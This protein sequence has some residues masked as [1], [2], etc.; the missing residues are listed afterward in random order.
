MN[1]TK[2]Q[3]AKNALNIRCSTDAG[4]MLEQLLGQPTA[5][6]DIGGAELCLHYCLT[7]PVEDEAALK[8]YKQ[9]REFAAK[10]TGGPSNGRFDPKRWQIIGHSPNIK[11]ALDTAWQV[12]WK[13]T[14]NGGEMLTQAQKDALRA[15]GLSDEDISI[16]TPEEAEKVIRNIS[17][18]QAQKLLNGGRPDRT[19]ALRLQLRRNGFHPLPVEGKVPHINGWQLKFLTANEEEIRLWPKIYNL[20]HNTSVLA[21][22]TPGGDI[23]IMVP[24]A[25]DAIEALAREFFEERGDIHVR[26]GQPPKRLILFRTDEPFTKLSRAF[27]AP[28]GTS[29]KIEFLGDGQQYVVDGIHP[30][31]HKPYNWHGGNLDTIKRDDLPYIRREDVER[32]LDA[33]TKLLVEEFGFALKSAGGQQTRL[34]PDEEFGGGIDTEPWFDLLQGDQKDEVVDCALGIIATR[35]KLLELEENGGDNDE[36]YR[37]TTSVARSDAPHAADIFVKHASTA[38]TPDPPDKLREYFARCRKNPRGITVGTLLQKA[39]ELGADFEKWKSNNQGVSGDDEQEQDRLKLGIDADTWATL[40]NP[41]GGRREFW[42]VV[43]VLKQ[44]GFTV[45]GIIALFERFPNGL[46]AK[47]CGRLRHEVKRVYDKIKGDPEDRQSPLLECEPWWR[48]AATISQRV[49]LHGKKHFARKNIGATIGAGGRLKTTQGLF[50]C[51]EFAVGRDLIT[52]EELPGGP[53][54]AAFL[55][56]EEDQDELDRRTAAIC[57]CYSITEADLGGRLF[58]KSV[59]D[60]PMRFAT[61][62]EGVPTLNQEALEQLTNFIQHR[63]LDAWMLDPWISFHSVNES[64]NADMDLVIKEGLKPV[65]TITNSNGEIFHHPGKPKP[66]Q[67]ETT[68][69]DARGASAIIWAVRS[70]RVFN[71][72]TPEEAKQLGIAEADRRLHVRIA[73]GK[74]NMGPVG[75]ASWIKIKVEN[76]PNGD[77]IACSG[78]WKPPDPFQGVKPADMHKCRDLARAGAYRADSRSP[79]WVGYMI[80]QVLHVNVVPGADNDLKDLARIRRVIKTWIKN[81]VLKIESREDENRR[82][83]EFVVPGPWLDAI[84][85]LYR[86]GSLVRSTDPGKNS[87]GAIH[88]RRLIDCQYGRDRMKA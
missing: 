76:L 31:T 41:N 21:K 15:R 3:A 77:E 12:L 16:F 28:D 53:L 84:Q 70:A 63:Q 20:A 9:T 66:G 88:L 36:W 8:K 68:V 87:T 75:T 10:I 79:E 55:N 59:C 23:D 11:I 46:A 69:E 52:K 38:I 72:M 65:A 7:A 61:L 50:E 58:V 26:V 86:T 74:A 82:K 2:T 56:A 42:N 13:A 43:M 44:I 37:L 24:E 51:I 57:Q 73:N 60:R 71:F 1:G 49:F 19:T 85:S 30:D 45:D 62:V 81:G 67:S 14:E 34:E 40:K 33:A 64:I 48:D 29:Q 22:F 25:A 6:I 39:R 27:I 32:F 17:P 4:A 83:R 47:Y 78:P 35:S 80:A 5:I 18:E 54:R